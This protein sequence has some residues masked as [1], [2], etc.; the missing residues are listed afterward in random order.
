MAEKSTPSSVCAAEWGQ[1][2][3]RAIHDLDEAISRVRRCIA[4]THP[5]EQRPKARRLHTPGAANP[6]SRPRP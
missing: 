3:G 4:A 5:P 2:F 6:L 1:R